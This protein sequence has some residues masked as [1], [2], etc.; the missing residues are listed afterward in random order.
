MH[1]L[2]MAE[3]VRVLPS[4]QTGVAFRRAG[5]EGR[6]PWAMGPPSS[7]WVTDFRTQAVSARPNS[8]CVP[9]L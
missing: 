3:Q 8:V 5:R 9:I 1:L 6:S 7:P 2:S 4:D